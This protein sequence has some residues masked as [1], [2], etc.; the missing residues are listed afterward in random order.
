MDRYDLANFVDALA[1]VYIVMI[2][3]YI[4]VSILPLPY[5]T[6]TYRLREFLDQTVAPYLNVFRRFVPS[7]GPLDIS[8]WIA[9][10]VLTVV[11]RIVVNIILG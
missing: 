2:F 11:Q 10:I 3:A 5:N 1:Y 4:I 6:F 9:I 8:P 7:F